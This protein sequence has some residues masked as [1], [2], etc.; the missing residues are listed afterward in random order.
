[1]EISTG[2]ETMTEGQQSEN[3]ILEVIS[4]RALG[5][6][7][8]PFGESI[9]YAAGVLDFFVFAPCHKLAIFFFRQT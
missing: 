5:G 6:S 3:L 8:T 7:I 9:M 2:V 1:M 4:Q